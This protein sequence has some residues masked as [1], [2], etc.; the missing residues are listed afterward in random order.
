[1]NKALTTFCF[2]LIL[3]NNG[4]AESYYFKKCKLSEELSGDYIINLDKNLIE[5]TIVRTDGAIQEVTDEIELITK[6]QIITKIIQNRKNKKYFLQYYLDSKTKTVTRQRYVKEHEDAFILPLGVEVKGFCKD[7]KANWDKSEIEK[8]T[9]SK[10]QKQILNTQ[11]QI[12]KKQS[13]IPKCKGDDSKKWS[14]CLGNT[15]SK[16]GS[17]YDGMFKN[18][19]IFEGAAIYPGGA[20]YVGEF[21]NNKPHGE[22][23]F[24][25][26]DGSKY[27][28]EWKDGK[29]EGNGTLT[30][31][32][33]K[34]YSGKF[35]N[36]KFHGIGTFS[37]PDGEKYVG[38][39]KN[40]KRH[41]KGTLTYSNGKTYVGQFVDGEEHGEGTC[42]EA[43]G[44]SIDCKKDI[45]STGRNTKN[46]FVS[47]KKWLKIS[48]YD[49]NT[50]KAKKAL[51]IMEIDFEKK[52]SELCAASGDYKILEKKVEII[53][54]D[55]TPAFGLETV[56]KIAINGVVE[57]K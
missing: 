38:E 33:G 25:Y 3:C 36:D 40:G 49:S 41:G 22:G 56:I 10:E 7:V 45:S 35:K 2:I 14:D 54:E 15:I 55:E 37:S 16:D 28:G 17:K 48:E 51:D 23:T 5:A 44:T 26:S 39:Y 9:T 31:K 42:F 20:S 43:D 46:V 12:K 18:G 4:F 21:K 13:S 1:M 30:W 57:C 11:E 24:L 27:Y 52:A 8:I 34:K 47:W 50:G 29:N 32:D 6:D 53:D 19:Q